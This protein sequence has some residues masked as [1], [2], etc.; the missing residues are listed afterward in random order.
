[1]TFDVL[2]YK[3]GWLSG[4]QLMLHHCNLELI[5]ECN[6]WQLTLQSEESSQNN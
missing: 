6:L 2:M 4:R 3:F 5:E 1:M